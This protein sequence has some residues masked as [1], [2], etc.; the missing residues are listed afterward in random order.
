[1]CHHV[2]AGPPARPC[3]LAT[4][5]GLYVQGG[6]G[7]PPLRTSRDDKF[8][9]SEICTS[10]R[11]TGV[12]GWVGPDSARLQSDSSP[13]AQNDKAGVGSSSPSAQYRLPS[14]DYRQPTT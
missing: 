14:T 4:R 2:G 6:Q 7:D 8:A 9:R 1:M 10:F 3:M 11:M 13:A 12:R 5:I